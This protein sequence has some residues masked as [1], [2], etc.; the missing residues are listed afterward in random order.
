MI[1]SKTCCI[2][3]RKRDWQRSAVYKLDSAIK[4]HL[5]FTAPPNWV[6]MEAYSTN[7]LNRWLMP[8]VTVSCNQR[9]SRP[10]YSSFQIEFDRFTWLRYYPSVAIHEFAHAI[11]EIILKK[12][13]AHGVK[14]VSIY[15]YLLDKEGLIDL[16]TFDKLAS[17]ELLGKRVDYSDDFIISIDTC[18]DAGKATAYFDAF[19]PNDS[20]CK[21]TF[22]SHV[23]HVLSRLDSG[24]NI[25]L[26][27]SKYGNLVIKTHNYTRI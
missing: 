10:H 22:G 9:I 12:D 24:I 25:H 18:D 16:K 4:K 6:G 3:K 14:F 7:L 26:L 17:K 15:R 13:V 11:S 21:Y 27:H 1:S 20:N 2:K 8:F 23:I 19:T 5:G